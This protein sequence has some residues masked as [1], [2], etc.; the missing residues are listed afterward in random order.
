MAS[1]DDPS[2][3]D[4]DT[5][6]DTGAMG[7]A[8]SLSRLRARTRSRRQV[9]RALWL[10]GVVLVGSAIGAALAPPVTTQV[11]PVQAQVEVRPSVTG[12]V[13]VLLPPAGEVVFDTHWTP[14][15][16]EVRVI[17]VDPTQARAVLGSPAALRTLQATAPGELRSATLR[18]A[19]YT[20]LSAI[21]GAGGLAALV[22]RRRWRRIGLALALVT[23]LIGTVA[24][25]TLATFD[26]DR[27]AQPRF[28]GLL[29]QAP[30]VA[31]QAGGVLERLES[32]RAGVADIVQAVTTLYA[33]SGRL[34]G[35]VGSGT[36][37]DV[38]T[39]L[40]ISDLHLN[41][42]GFDL[43]Q[44]V[45]HEFGVNVVVDT[46]DIT[47]WGTAVESSTLS[48]IGRLDVPY[49][50]VRGNHDS[51]QTQ[52]LIAS[53]PNAVVLDG[54]TRE[55]AGLRFAGIGDPLFTPAGGRRPRATAS[56]PSPAPPGAAVAT[57]VREAP[58]AT[59]SSAAA[60]GETRPATPSVSR[61]DPQWQA[62]ARL[63][64]LIRA[65]NQAVPSSP[66]HV[67]VVHEPY[68]VPP[69]LGT[70][71]LVLD[72]HFHSRAVTVDEATGTRVM[73]EG[74]T[75][76]A[77]IS[78]DFAAIREGSPLPLE[79]TLIYIARSGVRA[80]QV[81][82]YDEVTVGGFGLASA[83]VERTVVRPEP[84]PAPSPGPSPGSA[85]G[86]SATVADAARVPSA[87]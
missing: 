23:G 24:G 38:V 17:T 32:Y 3:T 60:P 18:A 65:W 29:S 67:A 39:V 41:P 72:G 68:A 52:Q 71:P 55:V 8:P 53:F 69:L 25:A 83:S 66:V 79:A 78:A 75:G 87:P 54:T 84:A 86:P 37:G 43:V 26:V 31:G 73:R 19:G 82:A 47:T 49:V 59:P 15:A 45:V 9:L 81:V 51:R 77:G 34:P 16:V 44:R 74:S 46:G 13:R 56:A 28:T 21:L 2:D 63:A 76:G 10:A 11:G 7:G 1:M 20:T 50:F 57:S 35:E 4:T 22:H 30:Y 80:G 27:F 48:W 62:G 14:V 42:L 58:A 36:G 61:D 70:V 12:G 33:M 6:T 40:H 85:P 5:D 64:D